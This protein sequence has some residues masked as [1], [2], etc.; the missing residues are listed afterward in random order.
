[1][2]RGV[3]WAIV[4]SVAELDMTEVTLAYA[5]RNNT[6]NFLPSSAFNSQ[7]K[8]CIFA[9]LGNLRSTGTCFCRWLSRTILPPLSL[10]LLF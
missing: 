2:D 9:S 6:Q 1:M 4:H 7:E 5:S 3:W 10:E 8:L